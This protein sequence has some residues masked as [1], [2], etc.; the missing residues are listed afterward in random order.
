MLLDGTG[1]YV[2]FVAMLIIEVDFAHISQDQ[3]HLDKKFRDDVNV[4]RQQVPI[5]AVVNPIVY[6]YTRHMLL[7]YVND[8]SK[9]CSSQNTCEICCQV[10]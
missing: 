1:F 5:L 3:L 8:C 2:H 7:M 6:C 4:Y 10:I 9:F